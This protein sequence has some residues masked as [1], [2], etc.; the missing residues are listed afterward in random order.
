MKIKS[1][2][3]SALLT[4]LFLL[5]GCGDKKTEPE[6]KSTKLVKVETV[7]HNYNNEKLVFSGKIQEKSLNTLSFRVGGPLVNLNVK[8]GDFVSKGEVI[9]SIDKRDYVIQLQ[10]TEAQL[11]QLTGEYKRYKELYESDKIP[12]NSFEKIESGYLMAK[13]AFENASNQ[14]NDTKLKA[15]FSGYIHEKMTENFQTVGPGQPIVSIIDVSRLEVVISV[16][17]N[18]I[19]NIKKGANISSLEVKNA[20]ISN[21]PLTI[22]S[23]GKK[24]GKDGLYEIKLSFENNPDLSIFPGMT[25][26]VTMVCE[27]NNKPLDI[28]STAVFKDGNNTYVWLLNPSNQQIEKRTIKIKSFSSGGRF[29]VTDGI[30]VGDIII[31][32]GI[33]DLVDGQ[34]VTPLQNPAKT[35]VGGLL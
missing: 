23:I 34:H 21:L 7:K 14:L 15:P 20:N 13:T 3:A 4:C 31:T 8:P 32:A 12:A 5:S 1:S 28:P 26:E 10:S 35:N 2:I 25:A 18:Q 22:E 17:E 29:I 33:Y 27:N 16:S 6:K 11:K 30:D 24:T 9:A 19:N